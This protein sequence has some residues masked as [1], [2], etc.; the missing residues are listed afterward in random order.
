MSLKAKS[1]LAYA[2][3]LIE[4]MELGIP[5]KPKARAEPKTTEKTSSDFERMEAA[6]AKRKRKAAKRGKAQ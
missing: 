2:V 3:A 1:I 5:L 4:G 6:E